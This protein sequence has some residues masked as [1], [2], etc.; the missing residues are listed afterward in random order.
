MSTLKVNTIQN[1]SGVEVYTA[2]AWV[3][4]NGTF[5]TSPFTVANGGIR[6]AG[7]VSSVTDM[8]LGKYTI[9]FT[10]AM[11]DAN[12]VQHI[13]A[14]NGAGSGNY[15]VGT[16]FYAPSSASCGVLITDQ[17]NTQADAVYVNVVIFR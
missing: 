5:G 7:N 10:T 11:P 6:Q 9:N 16:L 4:F 13:S 2:K 14:G 8:G 1:T 17:N 12:Y 3:N 15:Y